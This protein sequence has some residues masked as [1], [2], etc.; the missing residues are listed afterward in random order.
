MSGVLPTPLY[1]IYEAQFNLSPI[2]GTVIFSAYAIAVIPMLFIFGPIGDR[3]GRKRTL[4]AAVGFCIFAA[5]FLALGDGLVNLIIGRTLQGIAVG[6]AFGNA[7]AA[8]VE[9]EPTMNR[10]R[11]SRAAGTSMFAGLII[12]PLLA[13]FTVE[14]LPEPTLLV[15]IIDLV[16][17]AVIFS[18]L[19]RVK[20]LR[21][22]SEKNSIQ[23]NLPKIPATIRAHFAS[24]SL[25]AALVF[26]MSAL[27]FSVIPTYTQITLNTT[28]VFIGSVVTTIMAF[29]SILTQQF[30]RKKDLKKLLI[31]GQLVLSCGILL[32][33]FVQF[34][35]SIILLVIAAFVSGIAYGA[36]FLGAVAIIN[37]IAP[38]NTRGVVISAFYAIAYV[39]FG[40]PIIGL[41]ILAQTH[42]L[43]IAIQYYGA[44]IALAATI[45]AIWILL[46]TRSASELD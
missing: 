24:A 23:F 31:I 34:T 37:A 46:R 4:L 43:F 11:A 33:V 42:S 15:Y 1:G 38:A 5:F 3:I 8:L 19:L 20:E 30:L 13:G 41:G 6:A 35:S 14:Y 10:K 9:L 29:V 18:L 39:A 40:F 12:G 16:I 45:H 22:N 27:Y 7:T 2:E 25:S 26:S 28:N 32:I 17:L 36:T 21:S 44:F